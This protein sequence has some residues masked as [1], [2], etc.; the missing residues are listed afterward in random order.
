VEVSLFDSAESFLKEPYLQRSGKVD[1]NGEFE[2]VFAALPA[3][4]YAVVAVH[5]ANDN[6]KLDTGFLGFGAESY[7]YSNN[8]HPWF[9][10]PDFDDTKIR[11]DE[12]SVVVEIDMD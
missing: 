12:D 2:A 5:D 4:D 11:L 3:G 7:G 8:V 9:G 6:G 10:R 1:G